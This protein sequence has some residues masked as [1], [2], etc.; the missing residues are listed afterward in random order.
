MGAIFT[1]SNGFKKN[2]NDLG[3]DVVVFNGT[4]L[5]Q[6]CA[7]I[8]NFDG[9]GFMWMREKIL[10]L[11]PLMS[12]GLKEGESF[13]LIAFGKELHIT[14]KNQKLCCK[15]KHTSTVLQDSF[16]LNYKNYTQQVTSF[17]YTQHFNFSFYRLIGQHKENSILLVPQRGTSKHTLNTFYLAQQKFFKDLVDLE[18]ENILRELLAKEYT[19]QS[20]P[21]EVAYDCQCTKETMIKWAKT[22][23]QASITKAFEQSGAMCLKV[24]CEFCLHDFYLFQ[25]DFVNSIPMTIC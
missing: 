9:K 21:T 23:Q 1:F 17:N 13:S 14:K 16:Y 22:A 2:G 10:T 3:V 12:K 7:S 19:M 11:V 8:H 15:V 18:N 6:E 24:S 20:Q 5:L 4:S 25:D